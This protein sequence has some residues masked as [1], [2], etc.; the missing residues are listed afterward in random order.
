MKT[1]A[2]QAQSD[3]SN[4][5]AHKYEKVLAGLITIA[6]YEAFANIQQAECNS[7]IDSLVKEVNWLDSHAE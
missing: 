3:C 4:M 6:E 7:Y 2:Q 1:L 5:I